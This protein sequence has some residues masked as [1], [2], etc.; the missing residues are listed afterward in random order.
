MLFGQ[1]TTQGVSATARAAVIGD[2]AFRLPNGE[3]MTAEKFME[4]TQMLTQTRSSLERSDAKLRKAHDENAQ[5]KREKE[6]AI[7]EARRYVVLLGVAFTS[8]HCFLLAV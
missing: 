2:E 8:I 4:R 3:L 5:L 1:I 6:G 7:N